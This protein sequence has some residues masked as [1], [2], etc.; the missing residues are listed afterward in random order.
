M[1]ELLV[2][3]GIPAS[4]KTTAA[5]ELVSSSG[6]N[7]G[8]VNRDTLREMIFN[9][10]W[11]RE[12][13]KVIVDT[14]KAIAQVL[15]HHGYSVVVDDT[16]FKNVWKEFLEAES[17]LSG[18]EISYKEKFFDIPLEECIRRDAL[19]ESPVGRTV[20]TKMALRNGLVEFP[21][22]LGPIYGQRKASG[23]REEGL[24]V[25]LLSS[26]YRRSGCSYLQ[27]GCGAC[28]RSYNRDSVGKGSRTRGTDFGLVREGMES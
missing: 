19:R 3:K 9:S 24:E 21:D 5:K 7:Y 6:C 18:K 8:R 23:R 11:S 12:R 16:N 28:K 22:H 14:E 1:S 4:G 2:Y 25:V 27:V 17:E 26:P 20:I 15:L 10:K 13:E